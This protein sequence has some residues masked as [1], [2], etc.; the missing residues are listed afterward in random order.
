M[1]HL[2]IVSLVLFLIPISM[3]A[4]KDTVYVQDVYD[5]GGEEG[6]LNDA[7]REKIDAGTLS[8]TVFELK[9]HGLYILSST[10]TAPAGETL[11]I[12]APLPG[13]TQET[14]PPMIAWTSSD[15]PDKT[16]SD[17]RPHIRFHQDQ[18]PDKTDDITT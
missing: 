9:L 14:A 6:T 10:I 13:N 5:T 4:Q 17:R 3:Y 16:Y 11:E 15:E 2:F 18:P 8:N 12:V 7:V 1:K